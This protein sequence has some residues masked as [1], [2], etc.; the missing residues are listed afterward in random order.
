MWCHL[1]LCHWAAFSG[2]HYERAAALCERV[3]LYVWVPADWNLLREQRYSRYTRPYC[4]DW[5]D[6]NLHSCSSVKIASSHDHPHH[7][8]A[9]FHFI[10]SLKGVIKKDY[11]NHWLLDA[12][13]LRHPGCSATST[14]HGT[15]VTTQPIIPHQECKITTRTTGRVRAQRTSFP[16]W[17]TPPPPQCVSTTPAWPSSAAI[18]FGFLAAVWSLHTFNKLCHFAAQTRDAHGWAWEAGTWY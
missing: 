18:G 1:Q 6:H 17:K 8:S 9:L 11:L 10:I 12:A 3:V 14:D 15:V 16:P 4:W 7:S 2:Q 5:L 13:V